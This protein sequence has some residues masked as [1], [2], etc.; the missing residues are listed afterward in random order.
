MRK[1]TIITRIKDDLEWTA[2]LCDFITSKADLTK[3][4]RDKF[5]Y[6]EKKCQELNIIISREEQ[7]Q[8]IEMERKVYEH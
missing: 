6:I 8:L 7:E 2:D 1:K 4:V 5:S 3:D